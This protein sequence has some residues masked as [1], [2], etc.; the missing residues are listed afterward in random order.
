MASAT[1]ELNVLFILIN[2]NL[3][4]SNYMELVATILDSAGLELGM[5]PGCASLDM[6]S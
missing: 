4:L 2:L 5:F 3:S 6:S 1:K